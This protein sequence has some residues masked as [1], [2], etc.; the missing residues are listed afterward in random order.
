MAQVAVTSGDRAEAEQ[1]FEAALE[2]LHKYPAPLVAWK[3]Y[4]E[5]GQL[6]LREGDR[7]SAQEAFADA[8]TIVNSIAAHVSDARLQA[9][10]LNSTAVREVVNGAAKDRTNN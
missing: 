10:F 7:S 3:I 1:Q 4:A 6:K 5:L 8:N 2:E 9:I